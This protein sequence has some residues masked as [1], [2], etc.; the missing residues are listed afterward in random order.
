MAA[1]L[2][3]GDR[4]RILLVQS[5][6]RAFFLSEIWTRRTGKEFDVNPGMRDPGMIY[7][8]ALKQSTQPEVVEILEN[9]LEQG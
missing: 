1:G 8:L 9:L 2:P 4:H 6:S 3:E 5:M 7:S